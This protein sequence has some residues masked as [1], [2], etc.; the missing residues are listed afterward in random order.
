MTAKTGD[1]LL[2]RTLGGRA[3]GDRREMGDAQHLV[4]LAELAQQGPHRLGRPPADAAAISF[5]SSFRS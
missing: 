5:P 1:A 4:S 2:D 3:C